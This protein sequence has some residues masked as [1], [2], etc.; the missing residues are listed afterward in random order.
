MKSGLL[1]G[2]RSCH[3]ASAMNKSNK[4]SSKIELKIFQTPIPM[5]DNPTFLGIRFDKHLSF[6][7]KLSYLSEAC[8]KRLNITKVLSNK[9]WNI[10]CFIKQKLLP[11]FTIR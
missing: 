2:G 8:L 6:K 4:E 7:N 10:F 3:Q 5:C 1:G 9:S 11:K